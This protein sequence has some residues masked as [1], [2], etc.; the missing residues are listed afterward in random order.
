MEPMEPLDEMIKIGD[1][2]LGI[3]QHGA[4]GSLL[5]DE[6]EFEM[7]EPIDVTPPLPPGMSEDDFANR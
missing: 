4:Y 7:P 5:D 3:D 2:T 1:R 6:S